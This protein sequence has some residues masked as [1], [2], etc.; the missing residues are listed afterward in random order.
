MPLISE[1]YTGRT[2]GKWTAISRDLSQKRPMKWW[3]RCECGTE[4]SIYMRNL[5]AGFSTQCVDCQGTASSAPYI[6]KKFHFLTFLE[7]K[8]IN[9]KRVYVARCDCGTI[10]TFKV[11]PTSGKY[12]GCGRCHLTRN[13][14]HSVGSKIGQKIGRLKI[15]DHDTATQRYLCECE[16]G[17][18]K[19]MLTDAFK[20]QNPSCGCALREKAIENAK[21][22]NGVTFF[23][24]KILKFLRMGEDKRALYLVKCK[25][26]KKLEQS[27]SYIFCTKSCGC[28]HF[29]NVLRGEKNLNSTLTDIEVSSIRELA[30]TGLYKSTELAQIFGCSYGNIR[31]IITGKTRKPLSPDPS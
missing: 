25:C 29:E 5:K 17:T 21:R 23:Y 26:G 13:H 28:L 4:K 20:A 9:G 30:Q 22:L 31:A 2:F 15:L 10:R 1:D 16:C 3:C 19:W 6:G 7:S 11:S 14:I 12:K 18:Q 27:I 8:K 24:K